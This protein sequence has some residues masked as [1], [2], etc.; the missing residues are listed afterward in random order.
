M[1]SAIF[2]PAYLCF[3]VSLYMF[4]I[5]NGHLYSIPQCIHYVTLTLLYIQSQT[6]N[7]K[8]TIYVT[9]SFQIIFDIL[10]AVAFVVYVGN[11]TDTTILYYY[12]A[13]RTLAI[14]FICIGD[15][16]VY[17]SVVSHLIVEESVDE[18]N[19]TNRMKLMIGDNI[20]Q[21]GLTLFVCIL[22]WLSVCV[23]IFFTV[24]IILEERNEGDMTF[25]AIGL[26]I[27]QIPLLL[28]ERLIPP[29]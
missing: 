27:S 1:R 23:S 19:F 11:T 3:F 17:P 13:T 28:Q 26:I 29:E 12:D 14:M 21:F 10:T 5:P 22:L 8:T 2:G 9:I 20:K 4:G 18:M 25:G 24:W 16:M 6:L 15:L 7:I